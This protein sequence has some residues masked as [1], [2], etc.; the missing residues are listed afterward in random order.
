MTCRTSRLPLYLLPFAAT[1]VSSWAAAA[2]PRDPGETLPSEEARPAPMQFVTQAGAIVGPG[3]GA[4]LALDARVVS[5]LHLGAQGG[6]F[7]DHTN[8]YPFVGV[9]ASYRF[10]VGDTFRIVP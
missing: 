2:T 3:L 6:F 8:S 9:R 1:L 4:T 7:S 10:E 5:G